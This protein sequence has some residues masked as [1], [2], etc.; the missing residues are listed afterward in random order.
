MQ[1]D[2][3]DNYLT[4]DSGFLKSLEFFKKKKSGAG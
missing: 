2:Y 4:A 1:S 3:Q